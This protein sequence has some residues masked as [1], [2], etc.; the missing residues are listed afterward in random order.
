MP[1]IFTV[2]RVIVNLDHVK[3]CI[4]SQSKEVKV[5]ISVLC[6]DQFSLPLRFI[7][8]FE[9]WGLAQQ[10]CEEYAGWGMEYGWTVDG[11]GNSYRQRISSTPLSRI[12]TQQLTI[13]WKHIDKTKC[14][15]QLLTA[16]M[17]CLEIKLWLKWTVKENIIWPQ[18]S[19][20]LVSS[21]RRKVAWS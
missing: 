21:P 7:Y 18:K 1:G 17:M 3:R 11:I 9:V 12:P 2:G 19:K 4:V 6:P 8:Y 13:I 5:I 15:Q 16:T 14:I 10:C 20:R